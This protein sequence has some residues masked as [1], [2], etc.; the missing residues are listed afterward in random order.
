MLNSHH[1]DFNAALPTYAPV[2]AALG[3]ETRLTLIAKLSQG[4]PQSVSQ[5]ADGSKIT[6]QAVSKHLR[7]LENAG[8]V[9]AIRVGRESRYTFKPQRIEEV[10]SYLDEVSRQWDNTLAR[11]ESF[12]GR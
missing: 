8:F 2:F 7:V 4:Q 11:L 9:Q 3:D 10:K 6:R 5:L 12:L 1:N